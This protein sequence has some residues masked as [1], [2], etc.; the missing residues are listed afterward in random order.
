MLDIL[1]ITSPIYL[2]ILI[3][4]AMT[5]AGL[6]AKADMRV[7]GK[8]VITLALPALLVRAL[9]QRP[10]GEIVNPSYLLAYLCGSLLVIAGGYQWSR[11]FGGLPPTASAVRVMGMV[12]PNSGYVGYPILLLTMAPIAGVAL[13]LNMVV[14]NLFVLPLLLAMAG[15]ENGPAGRWRALRSALARLARNPLVIAM[16]IGL[17]ISLLGWRLP[18]PLMRTVDMLASACSGLALFV[19]G[20][21]LVGLPLRGVAAQ[22]APVVVGKLVAHPLAVLLTVSVLPLLGLPQVAPELRLAV[23][24]SAA[25]PMMGIYPTVAQAYHQEEFSAVALLVTTSASFFTLSGLLWLLTR[26]PASL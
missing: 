1:S 22:V 6:F 10:I 9:A 8:F 21:T 25:M 2:L 7:L 4:Y 12:C 19:V 3:G 18:E 20:G 5:R 17:A 14:E 16:F 13:A 23:V 11:R 15:G 26:L 24:L